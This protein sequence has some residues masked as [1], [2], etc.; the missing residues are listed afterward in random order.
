MSGP[1]ADRVQRARELC[2]CSACCPPDLLHKPVGPCPMAAAIFQQLA[3]S[4]GHERL[5]AAYGVC[6]NHQDH[7]RIGPHINDARC[8]NWQFTH[9]VWREA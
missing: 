9:M 2:G 3:E 6:S 8:I 1:I 4:A 5:G 7:G